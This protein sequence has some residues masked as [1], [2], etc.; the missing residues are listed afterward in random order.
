L[1]L[2]C[3]EP[4]SNVAFSFKVSR[5][6][7]VLGFLDDVSAWFSEKYF[8]RSLLV[9][10]LATCI[11]EG[12][13]TTQLPVIEDLEERGDMQPPHYQ[14]PKGRKQNKRIRSGGTQ[15][16]SGQSGVAPPKCKK[17]GLPGHTATACNAQPPMGFAGAFSG[18]AAPFMTS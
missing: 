15:F 3:D 18:I 5:Y 11:L 16:Q 6:T 12:H 9:E 2:K 17:C 14:K 8:D 10:Y 7:K 1:K 13:E 4:L